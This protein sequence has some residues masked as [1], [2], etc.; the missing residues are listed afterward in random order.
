MGVKI[1]RWKESYTNILLILPALVYVAALSFYPS[2]DAVYLS[3]QTPSRH[4]VL[5][6]Y[7]ELVTF[8]VY[9]AIYN[10][11][12]VT[13]CALAL[14]FFIAMVI[15]SLL[16]RQ[17]RGRQ[18]FQVCVLIPYSVATIV[19]VYAFSNIF[20]T[21][22]GYADAVLHLF[23][24]KAVGWTVYHNYWLNV[25]SLII[26]DSWKNTPIVALILTAGMATIPPEIYAAARVDGAGPFARFF[27]ITMPNLASYIAI[28]LVIRGISEFNI[29]AMALVLFPHV[30]LTTLAFGL[31][32]S[33]FVGLSF[34]AA[35]VLLG[36]V[37]V[38]ATI[39]TIYRNRT[40]VK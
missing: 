28:A 26:A 21:P 9:S 30:L 1:L 29:F 18:V 34:S 17:F 2:I 31:Y 8:G 35:V 4:F 24:L 5:T 13:I 19:T 3:F 36:F 32:T 7:K 12:I 6:N 33:S 11:I 16:T 40:Q 22:G 15:A 27:H 39:V 20:T 25:L 23:G 10:T 14:Q 37:L 38:F